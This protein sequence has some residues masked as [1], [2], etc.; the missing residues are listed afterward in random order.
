MAYVVNSSILNKNHNSKCIRDRTKRASQTRLHETLP[1]CFKKKKIP[2]LATNK[3]ILNFPIVILISF[4]GKVHKNQLY[5]IN[6]SLLKVTTSATLWRKL[7]EEIYLYI[8]F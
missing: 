1:S 2:L 6:E 5:Y 8:S 4:N 3:N 7:L